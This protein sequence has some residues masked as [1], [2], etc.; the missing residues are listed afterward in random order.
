MEAF[1]SAP[2]IALV[3]TPSRF[4]A[5]F[6]KHLVN[7]GADDINEELESLVFENPLK[8][9]LTTANPGYP[10]LQEGI[11]GLGAAIWS[12]DAVAA[13]IPTNQNQPR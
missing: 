13:A 7:V 4:S 8:L 10:S 3:T 6:V 12:F 2:A 1:P 11:Q 9:A 5:C